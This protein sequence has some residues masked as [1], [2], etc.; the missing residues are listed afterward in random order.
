MDIGFENTD[1]ADIAENSIYFTVFDRENNPVISTAVMK[2]EDGS[3]PSIG[4]TAQAH[5]IGIEGGSVKFLDLLDHEVYTIRVYCDY[6]INDGLGVYQ[7]AAI[8]ESNFTTMPLSVLGY[9]FFDVSVDK[10]TDKDAE[11]RVKFNRARTDSRLVALIS[12]LDVSFAEDETKVGSGIGISYSIDL[13]E[14]GGP[15]TGG[16][17]D[18]GRV[19]LGPEET[20]KLK[21]AEDGS[22]VFTL[23]NL[24]SITKYSIV[25][26]P[27][28]MMG[29]VNNAV[30]REVS[31]F[32]EP[33]SFITMK[34]TPT[35]DIDAIYA[36]TDFIKLYGVSVNDPDLAVAAYPVTVVV[37]DENNI[38]ILSY[39]LSSATRYP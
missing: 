27:R 29:N 4:Q 30:Y 14:P 33:A 20:Q 16:P 17:A 26:R 34:K 2:N 1:A 39:E 24:K 15:V 21:S 28:V 12:E 38:Q 37:Y 35:V 3:Y 18:G 6:D 32:Y 23:E 9:A 5:P 8:G 22:V 19:I 36:S 13:K 25:I 7:Y 11:I 10:V 31:A